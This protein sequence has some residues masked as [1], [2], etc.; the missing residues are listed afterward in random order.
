MK[1]MYTKRGLNDS[2]AHGYP[3]PPVHYLQ[4]LQLRQPPLSPP[5]PPHG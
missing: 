5:P 4:V 1:Y 3:D 2:T